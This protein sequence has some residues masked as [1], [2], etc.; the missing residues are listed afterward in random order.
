MMP[1][2][3]GI[4][5]LSLGLACCSK[6]PVPR[7][8]AAPPAP[9]APSTG[10]AAPATDSRR[11]IQ[12]L[13]AR[14]FQPV[15]FPFDQASLS[16]AACELLAEAATLMGREPAVEVT[17]QGNTDDRGTVEYNLALGQRRAQVVKDYLMGFGIGAERIRII[18]YGEEKPASEG[19]E[20]EA[21]AMNRRDEFLVSF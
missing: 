14:V 2:R 12:D 5:L 18:S 7:A 1:R 21:R 11:E 3:F 9:S 16:P 6:K 8:D 17:I 13:L 15:Y 20:E 4:L 19:R 10:P